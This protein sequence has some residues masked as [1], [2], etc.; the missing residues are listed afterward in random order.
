MHRGAT[1]SSV[2]P[3]RPADVL[4]RC[5]TLTCTGGQPPGFAHL[6]WDNGTTLPA[7]AFRH[8]A[9]RAQA[10]RPLRHLTKSDRRGGLERADHRRGRFRS[11]V[12]CPPGTTVFCH[13]SWACVPAH[14]LRR[15]M[16]LSESSL[17]GHPAILRDVLAST[18]ASK[19][20][21][22]IVRA[23]FSV[24][25]WERGQVVPYGA[26]SAARRNASSVFA[27]TCCSASSR[28]ISV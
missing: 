24:E 18:V 7:R 27:S 3:C 6:G 14:A 17:T 9:L 8:R 26:F 21:D 11:R 23:R 2:A 25:R 1:P 13:R 20:R 15:R 16:G 28:S 19:H 22:D 10:S 4:D 5:L 12:Q